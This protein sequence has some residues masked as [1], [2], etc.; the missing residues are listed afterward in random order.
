MATI[1]QIV[2]Q[3][4]HAVYGKDVRENIA[5]G[6]EKCYEEA[7]QRNLNIVYLSNVDNR[8]SLFNLTAVSGSGSTYVY[9]MTP[10]LLKNGAVYGWSEC[11]EEMI[12]F[13]YSHGSN[14]IGP[15][16][17]SYYMDDQI[18]S[19]ELSGFAGFVIDRSDKALKIVRLSDITS[20]MRV[21][22]IFYGSTLTS[23]LVAFGNERCFYV[24]GFNTQRIEKAI[25][26]NASNSF[27]ALTWSYNNSTGIYTITKNRNNFYIYGIFDNQDT[28]FIIGGQQSGNVQWVIPSTITSGEISSYAGIYI[29]MTTKQITI[30]ALKDNNTIKYR[31]ALLGLI[32][33]NEYYWFTSKWAE[34]LFTNTYSYAN[35]AS[36][37]VMAQSSVR[38]MIASSTSL[39]SGR[40][41][42]TPS[43]YELEFTS[44]VF[45]PSQNV[46]GWSS[47]IT[48][49]I[50]WASEERRDYTRLIYYDTYHDSIVAL[51]KSNMT[52]A[53]IINY[54]SKKSA[55]SLICIVWQGTIVYT[56]GSIIK[57]A[58][59][60]NGRDIFGSESITGKADSFEIFKKVGV[61]GDS[62]SVGYMYNKDTQTA[63]A[64]MLEY[65]WPNYVRKDAGVPWITFG[66]SGQNVL[67]WASHSTYGKVQMEAEGNKCQ[68]YIIGL[69]Q[70]D[71]SEEAGRHVDLGTSSDISNDPTVVATTYYGGYARIIQLI[72]L[73]NPD[74]KIFC[75]TNPRSG[76]N[77]PAYNTAVR[78][79]AETY[80]SKAQNVFL[81]D[82]ANIYS[83]EFNSGDLPED[84]ST[85]TGGHYSPI[86]YRKI[87]TII[88]D[89]IS[90]VV[91]NNKSNFIKV[92]YIDYD[93]GD[94]TSNTVA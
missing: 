35:D 44:C 29:N 3:I 90:N 71:Q 70:N 69:G 28:K 80:Y 91:C 25:I 84:S 18:V 92:A 8:T 42:Y 82:L 86:G 19:S 54:N 21:L 10:Y 68:A 16:N 79:I 48:T 32:F 6:I 64:R 61:I 51:C 1:A 58:W 66:T 52:P 12:T 40:V 49:T 77:R 20:T 31:K 59:F 34:S 83:N 36:D 76:G 9:T 53:E 87:A 5:Q 7:V 55:Y 13:Q 81:V 11:D 57:G 73:V 24:N 56:G 46:G 89:A 41:N 47:S 60:V 4:R 26:S 33:S 22:A 43:E 75:L 27:G 65:S 17:K 78:Y 63:T 38:K 50:S 85:I 72:K 74:A 23:S 30:E 88:E 15:T 94:P 45:A 2:E 93:H 39:I 14:N 37:A 67:T 62:L